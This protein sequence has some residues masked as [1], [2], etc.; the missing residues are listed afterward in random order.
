M[1]PK[2]AARKANQT[3]IE[4]KKRELEHQTE[5]LRA[6]LS[7]T[8]DFLDKAPALQAEVQRKQQRA[9][10]ERYQRPARIEGPAD[11]RAELVGT[12][13]YKPP[14]RL[15]KERS[16]APFVTLLLLIGFCAV[17]YYAWRVLWQG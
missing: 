13:R 14:K 3:A 6:K 4:A 17:M 8:K 5:K 1:P 10:I 11:F 2:A 7:E 15:R 12:R 9:I 16:I